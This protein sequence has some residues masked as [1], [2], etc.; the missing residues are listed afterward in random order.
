[1]PTHPG[2][3]R[4]SGIEKI[5]VRAA[6]PPGHPPPDLPPSR[7]RSEDGVS[8]AIALRSRAGRSHLEILWRPADIAIAGR[9]RVAATLLSS[10]LQGG[11]REGGP[12]P[13]SAGVPPASREAPT[14]TKMQAFG[15]PGRRDAGAP[16]QFT[17]ERGSG[18]SPSGPPSPGSPPSRPPP[19]R[20]EERR[21]R[22]PPPCSVVEGVPER[23]PPTPPPSRARSDDGLS[24]AIALAARRIGV[25]SPFLAGRALPPVPAGVDRGLNRR[26]AL[27]RSAKGIGNG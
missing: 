23:E 9:P 21:R 13:G 12:A 16:G 15:S 19:S 7:G 14:K 17:D 20:G 2:S 10:P 18:R 22:G 8:S 25:G 4:M 1:M 3:S 5:P 27:R 11:G 26:S 24:T 6:Q